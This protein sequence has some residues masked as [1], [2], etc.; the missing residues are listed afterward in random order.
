M[1]FTYYLLLLFQVIRLIYAGIG[2]VDVPSGC[3]FKIPSHLFYTPEVEGRPLQIFLE[4]KILDIT[5]VPDKGG[6]YEMVVK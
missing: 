5:N 6:S 4:I 2:K 3:A 1:H